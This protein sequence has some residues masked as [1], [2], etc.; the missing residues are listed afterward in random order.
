MALKKTPIC[1]FGWKAIDFELSGVDG[2]SYPLKKVLKPNGLLVMFI[3][4]QCP[5]VKAIAARLPHMA[6][7]LH[8]MDIGVIAISPND[9]EQYPADSFENMK[10]FAKEHGFNFPY[11]IDNTQ[12]TAKAYEAICTPD[13][14]G[15]NSELELQ[16]R[17]R[18]DSAGI[19]APN[20]ATVPDLLNAMKM[21]AKTGQGPKDQTP[22]MGCSIK[23]Q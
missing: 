20:E 6:T 19:N 9:P 12:N 3:C 21:V 23:W 13:F 4:N 17:G 15:F 18:L 2:E 16:Y 1:D 8:K 22:S 14:F 7:A 11:T 5:Y 10:L